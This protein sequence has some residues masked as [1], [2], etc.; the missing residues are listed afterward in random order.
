[1]NAEVAADFAAHERE[2]MGELL[3]SLKQQP[4]KEAA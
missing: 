2:L 4:N 1:V 3:A